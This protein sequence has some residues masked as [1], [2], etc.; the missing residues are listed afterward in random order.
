M[1]T[2]LHSSLR[3]AACSTA[4]MRLAPLFCSVPR[5]ATASRTV[6]FAPRNTRS[7]TTGNPTPPPAVQTSALSSLFSAVKQEVA[8]KNAAGSDATASPTSSTASASEKK[9][10]A[11]L[12]R[13]R[14]GKSV[15][16][17]KPRPT[18]PIPTFTTGDFRVSPRKLLHLA[19]L[20]RGMSLS[21]AT[22]QMLMSKKRP[23]DRVRAMLHRAAAALRHNYKED[24]GTFVV[25]EAW[26]GKGTYLKRLK[27]HGRARFGIMHHPA[28]HVK[29]VLE[30]RNLEMTK[31]ER[32]F[33]RLVKM[34][35]RSK[36]YVSM[37][38]DRP[39]KQLHPVWSS[40]PWKYVTSSRWVSPDNALA[41]DR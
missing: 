28:A 10:T 22:T 9:A 39:V 26:V 7:A 29:V 31:E 38:D 8:E 16:V 13:R 32:E 15:R 23:A 4:N 36:L 6:R 25:K 18:N 12:S 5:S 21:E 41:K 24:P 35:R 34:F 20:I 37:K 17:Q 11:S 30:K 3:R 1:T 2:L 40:K 14:K 33:E 19:R 27:I